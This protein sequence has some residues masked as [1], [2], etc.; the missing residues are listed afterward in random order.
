MISRSHEPRRSN[1]IRGGRLGSVRSVSVTTA[2]TVAALN[3]SRLLLI[4]DWPVSPRGRGG[5]RPT[6]NEVKCYQFV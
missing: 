4:N 3:R 2:P 6:G 5:R 1:T